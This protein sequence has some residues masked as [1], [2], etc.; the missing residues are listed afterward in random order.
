MGW[1]HLS[2][3]WGLGSHCACPSQQ[4][5]IQ[6]AG[7][8]VS[9][10]GLDEEGIWTVESSKNTKTPASTALRGFWES[11]F[12]LGCKKLQFF[13]GRLDLSQTWSMKGIT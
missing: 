10:G 8:L 7:K 12:R 9:F 2:P 4:R 5:S 6:R 11:T 13:G 3:H 1:P